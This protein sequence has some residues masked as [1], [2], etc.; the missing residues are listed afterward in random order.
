MLSLVV[1]GFIGGAI[2]QMWGYYTPFIIGGSA[3]FTI[4]AGLMTMFTVDQPD[5]RAYGFIIVAGAGGGLSLQN[6]FMAV[7]AVLSQAD[8]PI[9]NA[10][11]MFTQTLSYVTPHSY[12]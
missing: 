11:V 12:L 3:L 10:V 1:F 6:G 2:V 7:Q 8:L 9:G 5:W 4:G